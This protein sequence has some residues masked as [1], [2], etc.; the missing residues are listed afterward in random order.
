MPVILGP[1]E[2]EGGLRVGWPLISLTK[3]G[4]VFIKGGLRV[5]WLSGNFLYGGLPLAYV[6]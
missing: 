5:G 3:G 1:G 4:L 6:R 2:N